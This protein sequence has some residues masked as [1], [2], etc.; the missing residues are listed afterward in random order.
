MTKEELHLEIKKVNNT[1]EEIEEY[2]VDKVVKGDYEVIDKYSPG[3]ID[4][5][6]VLEDCFYIKID[7]HY[8]FL[9]NIPKDN[10]QDLRIY[11]LYN[12]VFDFGYDLDTDLNCRQQKEQ[13]YKHYMLKIK[14]K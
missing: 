4:G 5:Y 13:A 10:Y 6:Y 1:V 9:I 8:S 14:D 12:N 3:D 11:G 7:N 2:F